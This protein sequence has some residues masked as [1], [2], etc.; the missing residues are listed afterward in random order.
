MTFSRYSYRIFFELWS[1]R[2]R[3]EFASVHLPDLFMYTFI[4]WRKLMMAH[5]IDHTTR[6]FPTR[7]GR[8]MFSYDHSNAWARCV[9]RRVIIHS[10]GKLCWRIHQ[11]WQFSNPLKV[12][13]CVSNRISYNAYRVFLSEIL[14]KK[15]TSVYIQVFLDEWAFIRS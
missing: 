14:G 9:R 13:F 6:N 15:C 11:R 10:F 3:V 1:H 7:R 8:V 12:S 4:V 2:S 5:R